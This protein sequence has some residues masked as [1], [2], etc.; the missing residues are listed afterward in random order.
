M[1]NVKPMTM[2]IFDW[3]AFRAEIAR[4]DTTRDA[5]IEHAWRQFMAGHSSFENKS[6]AEVGECFYMFRSAWILAH[7]FTVK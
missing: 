3:E 1:T 7:L 6:T 5:A 2:Q 4:K